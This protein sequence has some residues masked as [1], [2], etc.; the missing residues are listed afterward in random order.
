MSPASGGRKEASLMVETGTFVWNEL[1][2]NDQATAGP[3]YSQLF[4]WERAEIDAGPLG[5]YTVF[6]R[7]GKDVAGMMNPTARD[8][9]ASPPPRW[10]AYIAVDDAD[11]IAARATELG[12]AVLVPPHDVPGVGR[13]SMLK[14]PVGAHAYVLQPETRPV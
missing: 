1:D 12:G 5:T 9:G 10:V 13:I 8:Y 14:D 7:N 6:R 2:T 3:F 4:G 11:A